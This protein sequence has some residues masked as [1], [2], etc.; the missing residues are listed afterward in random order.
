MTA[1]S[2]ALPAADETAFED[3]R[4][5][6]RAWLAQEAPQRGWVKLSG[7][8]RE[9]SEG[10]S[11]VSR[12]KECQ[13][14]LFDDGFAGIPWPVEYGGLGLGIREQ[15]A[16]NVES[17]AYDLPLVCTSSG[18]GMCGPTILAVGTEEQKRRY[19]PPMLSGMEVW[20]QLF[21]EPGAGSDVA[22]LSTRAVQDGDE[23]V[24]NGQKIWTS[25]A[26]NCA[27]GILIARSDP[28]RVQAPR[29]HHVHRRSPLTRGDAA[30]DPAGRRRCAL[31]RGVLRRRAH[32][33]RQRARR[34][35]PGMA[36]CDHPGQ[37][38]GLAGG[39]VG[40]VR[41]AVGPGTHR[42]RPRAR[43]RRR[44]RPAA[45]AD[46]ALDRGTDGRP[47]GGE[48]YL[49]HLARRGAGP[50]GI[51]GQARPHRARASR[52]AWVRHW[53]GPAPP[54][55]RRIPSAPH[56]GRRACCSSHR[57][58]SPRYRRGAPPHR[59]RTSPR[60]CPKNRR[61]TGMCHSVSW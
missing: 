2:D 61:S 51:S 40:H 48:D 14:V 3:F 55:G 35:G 60:G 58:P 43:T 33:S 26:Q 1:G 17:L 11:G 44:P 50:G 30:A 49:G 16:F 34:H 25:G 38:T 59:G 27:F 29:Y 9:R 10:E 54:P 15:I 41:R 52:P 32:P 22:G 21:S 24:V 23:S 47:A 36:G 57:C 6:T 20:C 46:P 12:A 28:G 31:Q 53:P 18:L 13:R 39:G 56:C 5:R 42:P 8:Q 19:I 7:S 37:R 4:D 45:G